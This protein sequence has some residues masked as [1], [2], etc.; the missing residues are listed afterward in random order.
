MTRHIHE[1]V[2]PGHRLGR[3]VAHDPRSLAY[4]ARVAPSLVTTIHKRHSHV[5][6]QG[7]LGSCTGNAMTG[8]LGTDPHY[9]PHIHPTDNEALAV[10]LYGQ[11]TVLDGFDGT[12]PPDDTGSTGLAV[13]QAAKNDGLITA[14]THAFGLDHALA[15][16]VLAPVIVGA[17]WYEGF[18]HPDVN[19]T[20]HI[21][22]QVRGGHEFELIG[23][24]VERQE[25]LAINSWGT[26]WGQHG[27]FAFSWNDFGRLLDAQGDVTTIQ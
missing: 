9:R 24:D 20:V 23:L 2:V 1:H 19:G 25:V 7:D 17:D 27:H 4:P 11:A 5:L 10:R 14:Y 12:Y 21:A 26:H 15:A 16:L 3:H 13:A 6:D 22:G 18:D 8:L